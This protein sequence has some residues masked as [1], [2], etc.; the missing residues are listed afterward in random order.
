MR[1]NSARFVTM[2]VTREKAAASK[3][4]TPALIRNCALRL[5][6]TYQGSRNPP[7]PSRAWTPGPKT[8]LTGNPAKDKRAR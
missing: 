1:G 2:V 5:E 4:E 3:N 7:T 6:H 8:R